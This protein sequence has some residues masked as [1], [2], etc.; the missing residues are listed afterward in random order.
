[1]QWLELMMD[2]LLLVASVDLFGDLVKPLL[3]PPLLTHNT[4]YVD[5]GES[6]VLALILD[7]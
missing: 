4:H 7:P 1:M 6:R 3:L 2:P 5:I